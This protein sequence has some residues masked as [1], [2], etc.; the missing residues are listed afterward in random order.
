MLPNVRLLSR[1]KPLS[2]STIDLLLPWV[3]YEALA[4]D[5]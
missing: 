5:E 4:A 3:N 2:L 1:Q